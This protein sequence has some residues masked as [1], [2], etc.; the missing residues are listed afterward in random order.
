MQKT[1]ESGSISERDGV[2]VIDTKKCN[3]CGD[4]VKA[5]GIG[6]VYVNPVSKMAKN[7]ICADIG[8]ISG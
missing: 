1:Y 6:A 8:G 5:C 3:G 2:V 7:A 4:C